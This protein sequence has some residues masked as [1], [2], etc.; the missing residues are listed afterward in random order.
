MLVGKAPYYANQDNKKMYHNIMSADLITP[1]T[2]FD[3]ARDLIKKLM[4]RE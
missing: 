4:R 3:E 2:I 1:C